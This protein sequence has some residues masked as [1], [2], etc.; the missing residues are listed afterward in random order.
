MSLAVLQVIPS[1]SKVHGGPSRAIRLIE[2]ALRERGVAV[3]TAASDDDGPGRRVARPSGVEIDE[4]GVR[5][6][7]FA[8][9]FEFYT[10]AP[11]FVAWAWRNVQRFDVV[12]AHALFS[13]M[14]MAAATVA[15]L[16]GVPYVLRPLGTLSAYGLAERRPWLKRVSLAVIERP[17]LRRAAAVHCTSEAEAADVRALVPQANA[18]VIALAVP[19]VA[20]AGDESHGCDTAGAAADAPL[21]AGAPD[22]ASDGLMVLFLSRLDR[23]KNLECLLAAWP[24]VLQAQPHAQLVIAGAG[25]ASYV[26]TLRATA[27]RWGAGASVQW[28]GHVEGRRK[29]ALH[30]R[31]AVFVLPSFNENFGIAAVEALAAGVP[32]VLSEG[33]AVATEVAAAGAGLVVRPEPDAVAG[34]IKG[35]LADV[36]QRARMAMAARQLARDRFSP[37]AL[38]E[39][40]QALYAVLA[41]GRER[42]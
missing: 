5:R 6:V 33:V 24:T 19:K 8:K 36:P 4:E 30:E 28:V 17:L 9:R 21:F 34:A 27:E 32:C 29:R 20:D 41:R 31:A 37:A 39:R 13:F 7:Y 1:L 2:A 18:V 23:K 15:R 22:A 11:A 12:H 40:L 16:R 35:L 26:A 42:A 3:L 14:S 25:E 38:G 10:T